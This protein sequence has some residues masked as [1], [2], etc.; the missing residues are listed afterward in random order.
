M[1]LFEDKILQKK[2]KKIIWILMVF[3]L[4]NMVNE[5]YIENIQLTYIN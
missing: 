2:H 3:K 5:F 1:N 4:H